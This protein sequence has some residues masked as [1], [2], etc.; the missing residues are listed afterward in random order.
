MW[1]H[2]IMCISRACRCCRYRVVTFWSK[3]MY[4]PDADPDAECVPRG[5]HVLSAKGTCHSTCY[6]W[7]FVWR[8]IFVSLLRIWVQDFGFEDEDKEFWVI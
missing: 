4:P 5:Q 6:G 7:L 1:S 3:V 2:S 8:L